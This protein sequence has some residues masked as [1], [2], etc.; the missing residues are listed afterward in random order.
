M[1]SEFS[2]NSRTSC[3]IWFKVYDVFKDCYASLLVASD[4]FLGSVERETYVYH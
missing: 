2:V 3:D 1:H 4:Q